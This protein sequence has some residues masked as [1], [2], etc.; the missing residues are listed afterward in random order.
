MNT[1]TQ[2]LTATTQKYAWIDAKNRVVSFQQIG[3]ASCYTAIELE[4]WPHIMALVDI[5]YRLQ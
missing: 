4:F 3:E 1:L 5:G 2:T